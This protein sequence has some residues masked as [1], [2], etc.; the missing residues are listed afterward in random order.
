M[1]LSLCV[2]GCTNLGNGMATRTR[3]VSSANERFPVTRGAIPLKVGGAAVSVGS[4]VGGP[5]G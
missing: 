3:L 1:S 5:G 4:R 2:G